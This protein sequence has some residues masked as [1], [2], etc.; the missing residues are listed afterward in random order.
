MKFISKLALQYNF[1]LFKTDTK[2]SQEILQI[3]EKLSGLCI[4]QTFKACLRQV[5]QGN[6]AQGSKKAQKKTEK[7]GILFKRSLPVLGELNSFI[8]KKVM[9]KMKLRSGLG[10]Q[11]QPEWILDADLETFFKFQPVSSEFFK[12]TAGLQE[13]ITKDSI[14]E[15]VFV[16][17]A[18]LYFIGVHY[19]IVSQA[20]DALKFAKYAL[21]LAENFFG[22]ESV[23]YQQIQKEI[24]SI[25]GLKARASKKC[26]KRNL[27]VVGKI[28]N[29]E[30]LSKESKTKAAY[31]NYKQ[32]IQ[33]MMSAGKIKKV[34]SE[35]CG[36]FK[37]IKGSILFA[38]AKSELD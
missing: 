26:I 33:R 19:R 12:Q 6:S 20:A 5:N 9:K 31:L 35:S 30:N 21:E 15:K 14:L 8:E 4:R 22:I 25:E 11:S 34:R 36:F 3:A 28:K 16:Y 7:K 1:L 32:D 24:R 23:V 29:K 17:M 27:S 38:R 18:S 2:K 10:L 13:E 37:D